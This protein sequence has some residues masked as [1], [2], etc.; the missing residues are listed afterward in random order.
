MTLTEVPPSE[1]DADPTCRY[2]Y[3]L[4]NRAHVPIVT[5]DGIGEI[6]WQHPDYQPPSPTND[7]TE[8]HRVI[9]E[10]SRAAI[11]ALSKTVAQLGNRVEALELELGLPRAQYG[12]RSAAR[13]ALRLHRLEQQQRLH[14]GLRSLGP[15]VA[16]QPVVPA[17]AA[18]AAA[19]LGHTIKALGMRIG[20]TAMLRMCETLMSDPTAANFAFKK[21]IKKDEVP[22]GQKP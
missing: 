1:F 15:L 9:D 17:E 6:V 12:W 11:L 3:V 10:Q 21:T 22:K 18:K 8:Q 14:M 13:H 16:P 7:M 2:F 19:I 20:Q 5:P 4:G